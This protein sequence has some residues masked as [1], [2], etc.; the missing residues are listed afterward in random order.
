MDKHVRA[1]LYKKKGHGEPFFLT[2][3]SRLDGFNSVEYSSTSSR[4]ENGLIEIKG[5]E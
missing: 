1:L 4:T 3:E 2:E 5:A